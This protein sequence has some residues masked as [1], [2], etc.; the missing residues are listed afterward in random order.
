MDSGPDPQ[1]V[2]RERA[3][4]HGSLREARGLP[5]SRGPAEAEPVMP[6][7]LGEEASAL[8]PEVDLTTVT[9]P[10]AARQR[11][12]QRARDDGQYGDAGG[13]E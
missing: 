9:G 2:R 11:R 6:T 5:A 13:G 1:T 12:R 4:A 7:S 3:A 8:I 10:D